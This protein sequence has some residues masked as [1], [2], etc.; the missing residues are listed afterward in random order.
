MKATSIFIDSSVE[1][2]CSN[3]FE[4]DDDDDDDEEQIG[5][6]QNVTANYSHDYFKTQMY[7]C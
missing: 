2:G 6:N 5:L 3:W 4:G 1:E 7:K